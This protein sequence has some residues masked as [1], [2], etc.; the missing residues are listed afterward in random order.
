MIPKTCTLIAVLVAVAGLAF[1][2][3][4]YTV[5][6]HPQQVT[7]TDE[8]G[9]RRSCSDCHDQAYAYHDPFM[10]RYYDRYSYHDRWYGYYYDPWWYDDY[11]YYDSWDGNSPALQQSGRTRWGGDAAR[12]EPPD[13]GATTSVGPSGSTG[14]TPAVQPKTDS[15]GSGASSSATNKTD[16]TRWGAKPSRPTPPP[17]GTSK[18]KSDDTAKPKP[19]EAED[20]DD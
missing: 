2:T 14:P 20:E 8:H 13:R 1:L 16:R 11:W 9:G 6:K 17:A 7:M 19:K 5:L 10:Y 18:K 3:G 15:N 4:C 12:P